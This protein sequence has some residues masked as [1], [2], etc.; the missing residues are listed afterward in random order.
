MAI[1]FEAMRQANLMVTRKIGT[2]RAIIDQASNTADKFG[3]QTAAGAVSRHTDSALKE[4]SAAKRGW[5]SLT[6]TK[7]RLLGD[8]VLRNAGH[9]QRE[10]T[11]LQRTLAVR[12]FS[13]DRARGILDEAAV[14]L[15]NSHESA[16]RALRDRDA[17]IRLSSS[18]R[19]ADEAAP[20]QWDGT[21]INER[22]GDNDLD[23]LTGQMPRSHYDE[24]GEVR[25][26]VDSYD[27]HPSEDT[28]VL[29]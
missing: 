19:S 10:L 13:A 6:A 11:D 22:R 18:S 25:T 15:R 5:R 26:P 9:G 4:L 12:D 20:S 23:A 3:M 17:S 21:V 24:A 16:L 28:G 1:S 29:F 8:D 14:R 27:V 7:S 2:A